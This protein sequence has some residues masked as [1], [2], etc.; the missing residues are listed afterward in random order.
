MQRSLSPW[1]RENVIVVEVLARVVGLAEQIGQCTVVFGAV[2]FNQKY[3]A[4]FSQQMFGACEHGG[5][6]TFHVAF[7]EIG[8]TMR[9][10][11][12]IERD[13]LDLNCLRGGHR[14]GGNV[15]EAA[16]R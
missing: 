12:M 2:H 9:L 10:N 16:I 1:V 4:F 15:T 11:E 14:G 13:S 5:L 6:R 3:R 7:N 8:R